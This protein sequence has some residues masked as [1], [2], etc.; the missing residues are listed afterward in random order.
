MTYLCAAI[1]VESATQ[2]A[3]DAA[4]AAEMGADMV[5]L[6]LDRLKD[7][8]PLPKLTI[9]YILTC[10]PTWEG[11]ESELSDEDRAK[12]IQAMD[13]E[14]H[15]SAQYV[16]IELATY[17][18]YP[19]LK[20]HVA[21]FPKSAIL[22][23][24]D[25]HGRPDRLH[26]LVLELNQAP[27]GISKIVWMART[28]RDNLEAFEILRSRQKPTIALCMGEAGL[29]SR[30]LA[31]K[32]G[33]FLTFC[34]IRPAEVT[35]PG[36][37]SLDEM[38]RL[39]RWDSIGP[40]TKVFGVVGSPVG[41]SMSPAIHNASF[42]HTGFDGIYL[43]LLVNEGYESF[44]AFLET[45]LAFEPLDL[46]GLS[47][48]IP[49]KENALRYL[50][51]KGAQIDP[52]AE[53]IGAVNTIAIT[54]NNKEPQL[55]GTNTDYGAILDSITAKLNII[56]EQL[57]DYRVAVLGAGGTARSAVAGLA[58][59]GATTVVYNRTKG[60]ADALAA[61][62]TGKSG[63]VVSAPPEKLCD[64]CCQIYI[65]TTSLGMHPHP[66][67]TPFGDTPPKLDSNTLVFDAVYNPI[68]TRLLREAKTAGAMTI[69][70]VE[71]FV[72][73]AVTQFELWTALKA[74]PDVMRR[75]LES[76]L[77]K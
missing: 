41:H 19:D 13:R 69:S 34:G 32:F 42:D 47:I 65:N 11:G 26:N 63:K 60:R 17:N 43:P 9:P 48:T 15:G 33:G 2:V 20:K 23:S 74:P 37:V 50:Q 38:K 30:V 70:G 62:F 77:A 73:Q 24:H 76:H 29:I 64:S 54:R 72:R 8:I 36:Q 1:F 25:F 55:F 57:A 7:P 31:K 22:S 39:Y 5:E 59:Y 46:T 75:A 12:L 49:H 16:D 28:I 35:A 67:A 68:E 53:R 27:T 66:D 56:R 3:R 18:R 10:R 14:A 61:E 58:H 45:F 4:L 44:K 21:H 40:R 51:E 52:L 6:R 71:M